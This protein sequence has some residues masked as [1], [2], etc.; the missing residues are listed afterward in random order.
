LN[1]TVEQVNDHTVRLTVT[2]PAAD[3]D[4]A[5]ARAY[6]EVA[7]KVKIPGF[8]PGKAPRSVIDT[9]VGRETVL[10]E[11]QETVL[12]ESY[13]AA[14][15]AE[16]LKVIARPEVGDLDE[17]L[18]GADFTYEVTVEIKPEL[19]LSSY[20]G[21]SVTVPPAEASEREVE[22]QI[23]HT[24]ER[25]ATLE[26]V[27]DRGIA[28]GD[29]ALISFTG[30]LDGEEYEGNVVEKYLY[31]V[32]RGLMPTD[33]DRGLEGLKAGDTT[34][35]EFEVPAGTDNE[36]FV[37]KIAAFDITV[38]E[39]KQKVLPDL[40]DEF[41]A[42]VG[43]FDTFDEYKADVKAKLDEAKA[44]GRARM[45]ERAVRAA[46]AERLEGEVPAA[47]V[48]ARRSSV[49]G[50][51]IAGLEARG[52]TFEQYV[53]ATG[54][55]GEKVLKDVEEQSATMVREELALEALFRALGMEVT[56]DDITGE[57][58][59]FAE[60]A[61]VDV[62]ELRARWDEKSAIEMLTEGIMHRKAIQWLMDP[63][64]VEIIEE[65]PGAAAEA[66]QAVADPTEEPAS[67]E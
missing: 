25:F 47:M 65:E 58:E 38:H 33:F 36:E 59:R 60:A 16:G 42:N 12:D 4:S 29:F 67:E 27:E 31:E 55:E 14:V 18:E 30:T 22:A 39:V 2:V 51:F 21:I 5:I 63:Q 49:L 19:T 32:G 10:G 56:E 57:I 7:K 45:L 23:E 17:L 15:E 44:T 37:G 46:L 13:P 54:Y 11:A 20:E 6:K 8:R 62:A 28:D 52:M 53:A 1:T 43:G 26:P 40:D 3:V 61:E 64:N 34:H 50:D 48:Q 66:E 9:H 35:V 41:A 24:R